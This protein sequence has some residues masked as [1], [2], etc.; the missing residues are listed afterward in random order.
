MIQNFSL[1]VGARLDRERCSGLD[2]LKSESEVTRDRLFEL[3]KVAIVLTQIALRIGE[4]LY[5]VHL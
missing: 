3:I 2:Y 5:K 1:R 4:K